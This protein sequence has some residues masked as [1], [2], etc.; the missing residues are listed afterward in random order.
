M[1]ETRF[2]IKE[3]ARD[4]TTVPAHQLGDFGLIKALL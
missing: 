4:R 1:D 2:S 3:L